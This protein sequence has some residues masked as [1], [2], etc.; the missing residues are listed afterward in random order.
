MRKRSPETLAL[1]QRLYGQAKFLQG[2]AG[3]VGEKVRLL[4]EIG[5]AGEVAAVPDILPFV[6]SE[7]R[8]I[9]EA[10]A[11]AV[12]RLLD[13]VRPEELVWLD[14]VMRVRLVTTGYGAWTLLRTDGVPLLCRFPGAEVPLLG[15]A[16]FH[17]DGFVREQAVE[18]LAQ[19]HDGGELPYLL[20]RA[21][22]WV[23]QVRE[24]AQEAIRARLQPGYAGHFV[25][26]LALVERLSRCGHGDHTALVAQ[27]FALLLAPASR[28]ALEAGLDSPD[29]QVRRVCYRLAVQ[30]QD[31]AAARVLAQALA[32][33]DPMVRLQAVQAAVNRLAPALVREALPRLARDTY[34]PVRRLAV[35]LAVAQFPDIADTLLWDALLDPNAAL[36][37]TARFHLRQ[38]GPLDAAACYREALPAQTGARLL[39]AI[40]GLG[41]TGVPADAERLLPYTKQGTVRLREAALLAIARLQGDAGR[42]LYLELLAAPEPRLSGVARDA[43]WDRIFSTDLPRLDAL[44]RTSPHPHVRR[45]ALLLV[46]RL[47]KWTSLPYLVR[48]KGDPDA[49]TADLAARLLNRWRLSANRYF[50]TP[51]DAQLASLRQAYAD[52]HPVLS[53]AER[54][55][56]R[57]VLE[58]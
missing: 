24:A 14:G 47:G 29:R 45:N 55:E 50:V 56:I 21:N 31:D 11:A 36:R 1:I 34:A 35:V 46:A 39:G 18:L 38:R 48:A 49:R 58:E 7:E 25:R 8:G 15:M 44:F 23:P 42:P 16:S 2:F 6:Q 28:P 5:A 52:C 57:C 26:N 20:I 30:G 40:R 43:L 3:V 37:E 27:I 4:G 54:W 9:A 12:T 22:D 19:R 13:G 17:R 33:R 10:A 41:E 51:T 32:D 53:E